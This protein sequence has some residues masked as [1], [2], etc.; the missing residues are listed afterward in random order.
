MTQTVG[1]VVNR[2]ISCADASND[3]EGKA[4]ESTEQDKGR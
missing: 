3:L 4:D 1:Y 2:P